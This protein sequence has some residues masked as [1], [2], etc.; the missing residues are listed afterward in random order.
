[1]IVP[2]PNELG[3]RRLHMWGEFIAG[4]GGTAVAVPLA[5]RAQRPMPVIGFLNAA[6]PKGFAPMATAFRQGLKEVSFVESP[7]VAI[8]YRSAAG[9]ID[10][11][12]AM[13]ADLVH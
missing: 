2:S 10:R 11:L 7:N 8:E 6:W 9:E 1:M 4:L 3:I 12:P 5:A 13:V